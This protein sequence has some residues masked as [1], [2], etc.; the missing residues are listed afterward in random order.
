MLDYLSDE[1]REESS[2]AEEE[3]EEEE[4][5]GDDS[6]ADASDDGDVGGGDGDDDGDSSDDDDDD[7]D[8][9]GVDY[10]YREDREFEKEQRGKQVRRAAT[11]RLTRGRGRSH[12]RGHAHGE[13]RVGGRR[14]RRKRS[15]RASGRG[16]GRGEG[17]GSDGDISGEDDEWVDDDTASQE[18]EF[19][20][21]PGITS[22]R[23]TSALGSIQL[24]F[25]RALLNHLTEE[26]NMYAMYC[27]DVL[28]R[29]NA[30]NW[31]G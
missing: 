8:D 23:P 4:E 20:D 13:G 14:G 16:A 15:A 2:H 12:G 6:D 27:R 26:T 17:I 29:N 1:D 7:D 5:V 25:T 31:Q 18:M 24:F 22:D 19:T 28:K 10:G 11:V 30:L 3:E 21:N 9:D